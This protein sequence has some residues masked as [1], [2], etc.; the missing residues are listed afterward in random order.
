MAL[1][2]CCSS[3]SSSVVQK[4]ILCVNNSKM[5][6]IEEQIDRGEASQVD[7]PTFGIEHR[8]SPVESRT[9]WPLHW[10][11]VLK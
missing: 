2:I 10:L 1:I 9:P 8:T 7:T 3:Q 4:I 5:N 6:S 11:T